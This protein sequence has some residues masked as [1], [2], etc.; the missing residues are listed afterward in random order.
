MNQPAVK[1]DR[2]SG[3]DSIGEALP[4]GMPVETVGASGI[5]TNMDSRFRGNKRMREAD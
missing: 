3:A 4:T 5:A 1:K 2:S